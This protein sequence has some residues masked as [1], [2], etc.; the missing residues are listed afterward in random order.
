MFYNE[1]QTKML[2]PAILRPTRIASSPCTL[3]DNI[4]VNILIKFKSGIFTIDITDH[5]PIFLKYN[6]FFVTDKTPPKQNR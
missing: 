5:F 4:F 3:I 6:N 2:L 1:M